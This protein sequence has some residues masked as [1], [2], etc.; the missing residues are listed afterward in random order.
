MSASLQ[1]AVF[2]VKGT[3]GDKNCISASS[4]LDTSESG[5]LSTRS[6]DAR[7]VSHE[8]STLSL[9]SWSPGTLGQPGP[10]PMLTARPGPGV[11]PS[12]SYGAGTS[13]T[14]GTVDSISV[15]TALGAFSDLVEGNEGLEACGHAATTGTTQAAEPPSTSANG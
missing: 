5:A 7:E 3:A 11:V 13:V 9:S 8:P 14:S 12:K 6:V 4:S 2:D 15:S 10:R 1:P